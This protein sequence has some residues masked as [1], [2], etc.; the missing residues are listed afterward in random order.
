MYTQTESQNSGAFHELLNKYTWWVSWTPAF[1]FTHC[2]PL[3]NMCSAHAGWKASK[4]AA[5]TRSALSSVGM[6]Q[7]ACI[8]AHERVRRS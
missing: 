8:P 3:H 4:Q 5:I 6:L 7:V 1:A 2:H